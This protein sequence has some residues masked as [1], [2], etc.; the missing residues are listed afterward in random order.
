M[1]VLVKKVRRPLTDSFILRAKPIESTSFLPLTNWKVVRVIFLTRMG[2]G[3]QF[4]SDVKV[5]PSVP[6]NVVRGL[7]YGGAAPK[8]TRGL[9]SRKPRVDWLFVAKES[10]HIFLGISP[11]SGESFVN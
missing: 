9:R 3:E 7:G 6:E 2:Y 11:N 8:A 1:S 10:V 5:R 4:G